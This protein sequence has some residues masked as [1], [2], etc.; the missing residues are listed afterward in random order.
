[1][2]EYDLTDLVDEVRDDFQIPP[3]I[4]DGTISRAVSESAARIGSLVEDM[5]LETDVTARGLVKN[6]AYYVINHIT[7]EFEPAYGHEIRAWQLGMEV[8]E[9]ETDETA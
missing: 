1:M 7:E 2:K 3:Y 5:D 4:S 9:D 6:R 8:T